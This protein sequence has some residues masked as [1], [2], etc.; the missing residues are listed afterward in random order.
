MQLSILVNDWKGSWH[1][2]VLRSSAIPRPRK[3]VNVAQELQLIG[4]LH[5]SVPLYPSFGGEQSMDTVRLWQLA[6]GYQNKLHS[7]LIGRGAINDKWKVMVPKMT[8][9]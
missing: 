2:L 3:G 9:Q 5:V 4:S 7:C 8:K 6:Y 1:S